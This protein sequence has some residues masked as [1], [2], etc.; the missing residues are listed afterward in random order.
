MMKDKHPREETEIE[1]RKPVGRHR[2]REDDNE[3]QIERYKTI[4]VVLKSYP[5]TRPEV[6]NFGRVHRWTLEEKPTHMSIEES[7]FDTIWVF[8][9][10]SFCMMNA[11]II[12]PSSGRSSESETPEEEVENLNDWMCLVGL[13]SKES[14]ITRR[15]TETSEDVE[16]NPHYK[17]CPAKRTRKEIE[18]RQNNQYS[19]VNG[20]KEDTSPV[21]IFTRIHEA[22][23]CH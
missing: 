5:F 11:V 3:V 18:W 14:M 21:E 6:R 22:I 15:N 13:V 1:A 8:I 17:C 23:I 16:T 10:I 20:H 2:H 12:G 7:F 9:R 4:I 19:M